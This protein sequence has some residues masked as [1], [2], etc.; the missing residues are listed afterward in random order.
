MPQALQLDQLRFEYDR[1]VEQCRWALIVPAGE[2]WTL[3]R[4][5]PP[6]PSALRSSSRSMSA[7]SSS[8]RWRPASAVSPNRPTALR[9]S[10][11]SSTRYRFHA[12]TSMNWP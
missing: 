11:P 7:C 9:Q 10:V 8:V 2:S 5:R 6:R 4:R 12:N 1:L 3:H